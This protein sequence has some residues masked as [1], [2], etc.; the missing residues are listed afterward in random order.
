[1]SRGVSSSLCLQCRRY[2][3]SSGQCRR[4]P[5]PAVR[6]T[7]AAGPRAFAAGLRGQVA[8][9][10]KPGPGSLQQRAGNHGSIGAAMWGPVTGVVRREQETWT[11][12][13]GGTTAVVVGALVV[14]V[15]IGLA[16]GSTNPAAVG[17]SVF[18]LLLFPLAL[19]VILMPFGR[20]RAPLGSLGRLVGNTATTGMALGSRAA[21][22]PGR[23]VPGRV[24]II[25]NGS[26][27]SRVLVARAL[28]VPI[29]ATVTVH[30]PKF[31][32]YRHAWFI[33]AHGLDDGPLPTRGAV[34]ALV[35]LPVGALLWVAAV[36][37][38]LSRVA[39]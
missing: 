34:A 20:R 7:A 16:A 4:C 14:P 22:R 3:G 39:R 37:E 23:G 38:A 25:G 30:G 31:G 2:L 18:A 32:G 21:G 6:R 5:V 10:A 35:M 19:M 15:V 26:D 36:L 17:G 12:R 11:G 1:M 29:G 24:L 33:R 13:A 9:P 8:G 28:D 27:Q